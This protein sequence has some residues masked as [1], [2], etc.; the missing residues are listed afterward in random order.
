MESY[1]YVRWQ[2][3]YMRL[4]VTHWM[5]KMKISDLLNDLL[6]PLSWV[7]HLKGILAFLG[8]IKLLSIVVQFRHFIRRSHC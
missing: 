1:Q 7:G 6:L 8:P 4:R 2:P 3:I 5:F